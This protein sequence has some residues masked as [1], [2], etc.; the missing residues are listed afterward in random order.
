[1]SKENGAKKVVKV[2]DLSECFD[3][4]FSHDFFVS[5]LDLV[6]D[7]DF[8]L[9]IYNRDTCKYR[10]L[11]DDDKCNV[12]Y[13]IRLD[14]KEMDDLLSILSDWQSEF[15]VGDKA[16]KLAEKLGYKLGD[17]GSLTRKVD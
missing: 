4:L 3:C 11:D 16:I 9:M 1:M 12:R 13:S 17:F 2:F 15:G 14:R 7:K 6:F 10:F 8:G 5:N